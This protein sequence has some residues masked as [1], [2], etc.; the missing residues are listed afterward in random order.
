MDQ[1]VSPAPYADFITVLDA[2]QSQPLWDRY[3]RITTRHPQS[4]AAA[5][6]WPWAAMAPLVDRAVAEVAMADAERR[7]LLFTNPDAGGS[8]AT[9]RSIS[10]GL[11]TLLPGEV[12]HA[13]RHTLAALRFVMQG[14]GAVTTVNNQQCEMSEGDLVLTPSW[15]WHE[16]THPGEGRMVWFDGLDLPLSHH[17]DTMFFEMAAPGLVAVEPP[18]TRAPAVPSDG[19]TLLPDSCDAASV[20]A[21]GFKPSR[22]RYSAERAWSALAQSVPRG[23]GSR[24]LRY[25]DATSGGPVLPTLDCYLMGLDKSMP[26]RGRRS[27]ASAICVVAEGEGTSIIGGTTI[28]WRRNDVFTLPHWQWATHTASSSHAK[29]FLMSDRELVAGMGY[30][31]EEDQEDKAETSS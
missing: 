10:G 1:A 17:L 6:L 15:T 23:D 5:H 14:Q 7:V 21:G 2:V 20:S 9:M 27:T 4:P 24:L 13:H 26:T 31:R 28:A 19:A 29:L 11:Q 30:L 22:F 3:H 25:I 12:A 18:P 16:H 8:V